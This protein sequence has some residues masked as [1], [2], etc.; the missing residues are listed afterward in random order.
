MEKTQKFSQKR[1]AIL[2]A[3]RG[4]DT[5]P[6]AEW[7]YS[8]LK[9]EIPD[10]SLGTVYR[11]IAL[12]KKNGDIAS[13]A[14]VCGQE[15]LDGRTDPHPHFICDDCGRVYDL[16]ELDI[17]NDLDRRAERASGHSVRGHDLLFHGC[18]SRC[19]TAY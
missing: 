12:F 17:G 8:A 13:V 7:V 10:L 4:A 2:D 18:C 1:Q 3:I 5:H 16:E 9:P 11:N 14:V 19:L 6:A 15:R